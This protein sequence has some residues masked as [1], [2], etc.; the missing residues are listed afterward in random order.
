[1]FT[2]YQLGIV[3][4]KLDKKCEKKSTPFVEGIEQ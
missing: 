2:Y 3:L 1:M 4:K